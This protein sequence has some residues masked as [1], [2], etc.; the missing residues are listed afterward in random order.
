MTIQKK[1]HL[2]GLDIGSHSIKL[3]EIEDTKKGKILKNFGII[4]L[5]QEAIVEGIIKEIEIVSSAI[6]T[7]Y[8]NLKVKNKNVVTSI[9]GYS[10]IV[11]KI[12]IPKKN[13]T[14]LETSIQEEAEQYIP[15]DIN[16]VN[17]DYEVLTPPA[18][19]EKKGEE[20]T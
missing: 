13:E 3:V 9:S 17:L 8:K 15:F 2:V 4:G 1:N 11:K 14:E 5:P 20:E 18:A 19:S 16:D 12:S 6:K 7:L 10:V